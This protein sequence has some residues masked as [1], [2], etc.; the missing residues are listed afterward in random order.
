MRAEDKEAKIDNFPGTS[1][2]RKSSQ[3]TTGKSDSSR[4]LISPI[5]VLDYADEVI[6]YCQS[7]LIVRLNMW[8]REM[9]ISMTS[10]N[11]VG[12]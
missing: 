12:K 4:L 9:G 6:R 2:R 3:V 8:V 5:D 1:Q 7:R 11:Q 10:E